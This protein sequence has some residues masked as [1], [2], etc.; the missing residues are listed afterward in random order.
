MLF[1]MS[2]TGSAKR[3]RKPKPKLK[4]SDIQ[5]TKYLARFMDL[6]APLHDH[7]PDPKRNLHYDQ[8]C[9]W[10][11]LY[12]FTP[13]LDSLRGLQ[14][15]SDFK[16]IQR[17][18]GLPRFSLGSFSEASQVFDPNLLVPILEQLGECLDDIEPDTRLRSLERRPTAVDGTLLHA[19]PKMVWALWLDDEHRAAKL[20]LQ[21]DLLKGAPVRATLTDGQG[22]ETRQ[23]RRQ[24]QAGRLYVE[25]RGYFE[26]DLMADI[27]QAGSSFVTR[28]AN[29]IAC[30]VLE[31]RPIS[32]ADARRGVEADWIVRAGCKQNR[33]TIDR[34]LRLVR[35][36][37]RE[38]GPE[39]RRPNRVDA[40]TK[41]Y[42]SR[43]S[44]YTLILLTDQMDLD[45][46]L[47]GLLFRYRW[48]IEL[49]FR[50][51]K[52][53]L[54][55]DRLLA[56][57][58]NG[59]TIVMYCALLASQLIVLWTGRKPTKRTFEA[60]CFYF[61]GWIDDEDLQDHLD[62]LKTDDAIR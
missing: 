8:F 3:G 32:E 4:R 20:H 44:E 33:Q 58:E 35:I 21:F 42:R 10:L 53:V 59:M 38:T 36:H 51:F 30:D 28:V 41:M 54:Q 52:K 14:K 15:A 48:Q 57:S 37:L 2:E 22:S 55:A 56:L 16:S 11:L 6:L 46:S 27:L 12:F 23:L 34:P 18:L 62:R 26:Y 5:G 24:L 49:F 40:K 9:A 45:V 61:S 29:N 13:A 25:D 17:K 47:I 60:L 1:D 19:L 31:E 7:C 39:R 50:W 43:K